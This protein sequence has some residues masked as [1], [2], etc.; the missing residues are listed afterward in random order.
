MKNQKMFWLVLIFSGLF[1]L[2]G[3]GAKDA[4]LEAAGTEKGNGPIPVKI[5]TVSESKSLERTVNY[6]AII[7][8]ERETNIVAKISGTAR[9][10]NFNLGDKVSAGRTLLSIDDTDIRGSK[11]ASG[12]NSNQIEQA[13]LA[14]EQAE[15]SYKLA[16][17]NLRIAKDAKDTTKSQLAAAKSQ[18]DLAELQL[19][20]ARLTLES[21]VDSHLIITPLSGVVTQKNV[22]SGGIVSQGEVLAV[23]S[24]PADI[25]VQFFV[26]ENVLSSLK[27]GEAVVIDN[28]EG[29]EWTGTISAISLEADKATKRF[30]VEVAPE[31]KE[32]QILRLGTVTN[33]KLKTTQTP[34]EARGF[35]L[36]LSAITVGQNESFI[37]IV[38]NGRAKK[39]PVVISNVNGEMAEVSTDLSNNAQVIVEGNKLLQEGDAVEVQS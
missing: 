1:A 23:V 6:P 19:Q 16:K 37:F 36:R 5:Q 30:L 15:E 26:E 8:G 27:K 10:V 20:S 2:S 14:V 32:G 31:E 11:S 28:G 24:D 21:A 22:A 38:E 4:E 9:G 3:C 17:K 29:K 18:K 25:A 12:L 33:V 34:R 39:V 35:L 7:S 13:S